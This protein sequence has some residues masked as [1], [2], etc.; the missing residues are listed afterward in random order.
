MTLVLHLSNNNSA[1]RQGKRTYRH[2]R[3]VPRRATLPHVHKSLP[4]VICLA[5]V[6]PVLDSLVKVY[7]CPRPVQLRRSSLSRLEDSRASFRVL[8]IS[9]FSVEPCLVPLILTFLF[10]C[11]YGSFLL[12][13]YRDK[14]TLRGFV[15]TVYLWFLLVICGNSIATS[16]GCLSIPIFQTH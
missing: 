12:F 15:Y 3:T 13:D 2:S 5:R 9:H 8:F 10:F 14:S 11:V 16:S 4:K 1:H 6:N 7:R